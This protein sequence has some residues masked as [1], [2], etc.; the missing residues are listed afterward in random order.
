MTTEALRRPNAAWKLIRRRSADAT[1]GKPGER[2]GL[3]GPWAGLY[4]P[5]LILALWWVAAD[6]HWV[7]STILPAPSLVARSFY[8]MVASGELADNLG[9]SLKRVAVG[10]VIGGVLGLLLGT[11][12]GFSRTFEAWIG[13]LFRTIAQIP[14]LAWIPLLMM[15]LGIGESLKY[16][17][18][19]KAC[20]VP[21]TI[22][23]AAGIRNIPREYLEVG[24]LLRLSDRTLV[25]KVI[26]PGALP[27]IFSGVRQGLAHVWTTLIIVEMMASANGLGYLMSWA[28]ML[29]Q[30][31]VVMV[32]VVIIGVIGFCLDAVLKRVEARLQVWRG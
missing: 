10:F 3:L 28:R 16:V 11:A 13:P 21:I 29:F 14:S 27:S 19:A 24:K 12:M 18:L 23:T 6:S 7:A 20:L 5:A 4:L 26:F 25:T 1:I 9:A 2:A 32:C 31:D 22:T 17:V 8:D 30:L 15:V